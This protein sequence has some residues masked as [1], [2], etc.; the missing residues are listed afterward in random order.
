MEPKDWLAIKC[1]DLEYNSCGSVVKLSSPCARIIR[2]LA[3]Y[4]VNLLLIFI[5]EIRKVEK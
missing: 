4:L 2:K 1:I 5:A 3:D